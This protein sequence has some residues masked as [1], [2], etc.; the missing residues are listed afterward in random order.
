MRI[1]E[2]CLGYCPAGNVW[3]PGAVQL[4]HFCRVTRSSAA[5]RR[6]HAGQVTKSCFLDKTNLSYEAFL[7]YILTAHTAIVRFLF[8]LGNWLYK[9]FIGNFVITFPWQMSIDSVTLNIHPFITP[10]GEGKEIY[11]LLN[12]I[13]FFNE[14][15]RNHL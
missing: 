6:E 4:A 9:I 13:C 12:K 5:V 7:C 8:Y 3:I 2:L 11:W 14:F 10:M 15:M 1:A